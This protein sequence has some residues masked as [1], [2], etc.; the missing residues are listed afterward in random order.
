MKE[1]IAFCG[2]V[3]T[4]C[5]AYLAT[6]ADD[7]AAREQVAAQWREEFHAPGIT[8]ASINCDG[9]LSTEGR[10]FS[11]CPECKIR[12][13]GRERGVT[14]CA[15]CPEYKTCPELASFFGF[16]PEAKAKLDEIGGRLVN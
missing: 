10:L 15:H 9:C 3:C 14:N 11:H 5:P 8:A 7:D 4:G 6:Q 16:A 2:L 1:M 12:A 13:C